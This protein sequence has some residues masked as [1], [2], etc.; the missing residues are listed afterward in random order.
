MTKQ[1]PKCDCG[2]GISEVTIERL[3]PPVRG[4][5]LVYWSMVTVH[6]A[7]QEE[8]DRQVV[9]RKRYFPDI[10]K[11]IKFAKDRLLSNIKDKGEVEK[12]WLCPECDTQHSISDPKW[13]DFLKCNQCGWNGEVG[14]IDKKTNQILPRR[15]K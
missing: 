4:G 11:A 15:D 6:E 8:I 10:H 3:D 13:Y 7:H 12:E 2:C 5:Y 14:K 9:E 1:E